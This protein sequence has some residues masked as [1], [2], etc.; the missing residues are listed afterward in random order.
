MRR[1]ARRGRRPAG[2]SPASRSWGWASERSRAPGARAKTGA[3]TKSTRSSS[4]SASVPGLFQ[5]MPI[6]APDMR[7]VLGDARLTLGKEK[8]PFDVIILDAYSSD[9]VPVHLLTGEAMELY[10]S[11][12]APH[13]VIIMNITNRNME[14]AEVVAASAAAADLKMVSKSDLSKPKFD[15]A[16]HA[17]AEVAALAR[18]AS[19][20]GVLGPACGW[21][22]VPADPGFRT[23]T[24]DYSNVL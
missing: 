11:L 8:Q 20:F 13:G 14:L 2:A 16:F 19:D 24:D 21:K 12:L 7:I 5:T 6:C 4:G 9:N 18:D 3:S 1:S 23:W 15:V 22:S 17:A 10:R